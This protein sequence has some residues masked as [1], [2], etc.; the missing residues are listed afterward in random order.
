MTRLRLSCGFGGNV[1][2]RL[3]WLLDGHRTRWTNREPIRGGKDAQD[4]GSTLAAVRDILR[5]ERVLATSEQIKRAV[6]AL[7]DAFG[8]E[9]VEVEDGWER[10]RRSPRVAATRTLIVVR[11]G[12]GTETPAW[13][14]SIARRLTPRIAIGERLLVE[15]PVYRDFR[16]E[17]EVTVAA[18]RRAEEVV[19]AIQR[20]L[21]ERFGVVKSARPAWPLGRD[22]DATAIGGW[23]RR[24]DGVAGVLAV[25]LR[26]NSGRALDSVRVGRGELPRLIAPA[27]VAIAA[28]S[29]R[30]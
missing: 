25:T 10:G 15:A 9:R 22:V 2:S 14:R 11:R 5:S 7:P 23:I 12:S 27:K 6:D 30:P 18:S 28:G 21:A 8:I 20:D 17:A 16:I 3:E 19:G 24:V 29:A 1:V 13:R 4:A 26:D